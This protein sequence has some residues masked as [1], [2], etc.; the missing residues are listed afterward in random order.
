[1]PT[2]A[3]HAGQPASRAGR[4]WRPVVLAS[5]AAGAACGLIYELA[6]LT[7]AT[8]VQ[9]GGIVATSLVVAGYVAALG[10]GALL[11]KPFVERAASSFIAVEATLGLVGGVS[12]TALYVTFTTL[13][14]DAASLFTLVVATAAIGMLVGAEVPLLMSL[15]QTGRRTGSAEAGRVLA[16]LNAADYLG[17]LVGGLLWPFL[18][19]PSFGMQQAAAITGLVN[20]AA[21]TVLLVLALRGLLSRTQAVVAG[22][23]LAVVAA[24]LG[25]LLVAL[26]GVTEWSRAKLYPDPVLSHTQSAYQEIVVTRAR[27]NGRTD[28]RLYLDGTLQYSSLDEYRY[29]EALV[30]PAMANRPGEVL[31]LGGGDG[32]AA[33]DL[34][35]VPGVRRVVQVEL[36][37]AVLEIA[38]TELLPDNRG[39]LDD[40]RVE[41]V[42]D[43][44]FAWLRRGGDGAV[45]PGGFGAV[46]V[47]LPDP[48]NAALTRLYSEEFYGLVRGVTGEDGL[49]VVQSGSPYSTPRQFWR[50]VATVDSAGWGTT[51]YHVHV[52]TFGDWGFVLASAD[53]DAPDLRL[54]PDV[55]GLRFLDPGTLEAAGR[56]GRDVAP[57]RLEPS[58]L[59]RPRI[60]DDARRGY[61]R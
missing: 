24:L 52:P 16:D 1:M 47:D 6:L 23:S 17:A 3:D 29:T 43:D 53:G 13:G 38:R 39:S 15:L 11:A 19:L 50:T 45:P 42:V 34:L 35:A 56:F 37:P 12:A 30:Q 51:P 55:G 60:L 26:D 20:V 2:G 4:W 18:L 49:M 41:V 9:G 31:V 32:L 27:Y 5:V 40:P 44:A 36:D 61:E 10:L 33:R 28:R 48:R 57:M 21:A 14:S 7:L 22:L 8:T 59:D 54:R 46:L 25:T 58:T